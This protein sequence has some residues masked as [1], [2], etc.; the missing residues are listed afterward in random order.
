LSTRTL[1][2]YAISSFQYR[3]TLTVR[4]GISLFRGFD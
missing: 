2:M 1:G 3:A 4:G